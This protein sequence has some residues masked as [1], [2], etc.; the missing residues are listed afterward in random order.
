MRVCAAPAPN[1]TNYV[2]LLR[3]AT[4]R[5]IRPM[6][7]LL[8][9]WFQILLPI[10]ALVGALST[11]TSSLCSPVHGSLSERR[12]WNVATSSLAR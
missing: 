9:V 2:A 10:G 7:V 3:N 5:G 12:R 11:F 6:I 8:P 4:A 1:D